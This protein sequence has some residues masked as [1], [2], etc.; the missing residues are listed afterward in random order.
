MVLDIKIVI[1]YRPGGLITGIQH[2]TF[3]GVLIMLHFSV[4]ITQFYVH[5]VKIH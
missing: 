3:S 5:T 1:S 2:K 4:M